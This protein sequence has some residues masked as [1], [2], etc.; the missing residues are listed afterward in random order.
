M[1]EVVIRP[2]Q[3]SDEAAIGRL[4]AAAFAG[5]PYGHNGEAGIV[6]A[7]RTDGALAVS[8]VAVMGAEVVGHVAFSLV[9]IGGAAGGWY[10]LGPV[11]V[12]P[13]RQRQGIGQALIRAG[14]D[15]LGELD[16]AGCV[17]LG[18]PDYYRRF[19]FA[20]D[21]ALHYANAP[22]PY[23]QRLILKGPAPR[24]EAVYHPAFG[25]TE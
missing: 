12:D 7:L 15:R 1:S 22:A 10:G 5:T 17:V 8:Q 25:G 11:S 9:S 6:E 19:G 21:P 13:A 24:G 4:T 14:L 18:D 3:P 20:S 2:E 16:A 23:F